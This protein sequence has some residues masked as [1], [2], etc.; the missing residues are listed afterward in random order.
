MSHGCVFIG[1]L[2]IDLWLVATWPLGFIEISR[3]TIVL[4]IL[5]I[6]LFGFID[7]S[8]YSIVLTRGEFKLFPCSQG[9]MEGLQFFLKN[10]RWHGHL[11]FYSISENQQILNKLNECGWSFNKRGE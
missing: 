2:T 6:K 9:S 7:S 5:R 4:G 3:E 10:N 8:L 11:V 1:S